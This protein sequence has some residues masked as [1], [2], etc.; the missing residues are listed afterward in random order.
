MCVC[1]LNGF[2][3]SGPR[4]HLHSILHMC[5]M[6]LYCLKFRRSVTRWW[7]ILFVVLVR[8][9]LPTRRHVRLA[10]SIW[11]IERSCRMCRARL[12]WV[13]D[14]MMMM[15]GGVWT[16]VH[17]RVVS[18]VRRLLRG[19][20]ASRSTHQLLLILVNHPLAANLFTIF[21][22]IGHLERFWHNFHITMRLNFCHGH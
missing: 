2:I 18:T 9:P 15:E 6:F 22:K 21:I 5:T 19:G 12:R 14:R 3:N 10:H 8:G 17:G 4:G 20:A 7:L 11:T 16:W 1:S 13:N